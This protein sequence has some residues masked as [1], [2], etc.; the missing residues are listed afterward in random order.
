MM[1]NIH[2]AIGIHDK[3]G[4]YSKY[5][6]TTLISV[7]E[8]LVDNNRDNVKVIVHILHD[9]TLLEINKQKFNDLIERYNGEIEF[10]KISL[11]DQ[12]Y[13][14][15]MIS[16]F[17]VQ[18]KRITIGALFRLFIPS[19]CKN[20]DKIIYLD[21]DILVNCDIRDL[22]NQDINSQ[23][24]G[25]V[26]D[27]EYMRSLY[28]NTK[29]YKRAGLEVEKF[30][31]SGV[32]LLNCRRINKKMDLLIKSLDLLSRYKK[33]ADQDILNI[34]FKDN[35]KFLDKKFNILVDSQ[36][37]SVNEIDEYLKTPSIIH[38]AG[39]LKPWNC[40]NKNIIKTYY[41]YLAKTPWGEKP[42]DLIESMS[43]IAEENYSK[44]DLKNILFSK[45]KDNT[46]ETLFILLLK[47]FFSNEYF[48]YIQKKLRYW[49]LHFLF[50]YLF[51][52]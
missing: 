1:E 37:F 21:T 44:M 4:T 22:W 25:V 52:K 28:V 9:E 30:F 49:K 12:G 13:D 46:L 39:D 41:R 27:D 24:A 5:A 2:I 43:T 10:H 40:H 42:N 26:L 32:L 31:N 36:T 23:F 6:A 34:L 17:E 3:N 50:N 48:F 15:R 19:V 29:Y 35:V 33:F 20:T 7:F 45:E 16:M 51:K 11:H 14:E 8:N 47:S 18:L 38:F